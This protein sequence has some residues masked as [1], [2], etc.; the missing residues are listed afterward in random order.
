[1]SLRKRIAVLL[2][3]LSIMVVLAVPP[4]M[5]SDHD[6]GNKRADGPDANK[7]GGQEKPKNENMKKGQLEL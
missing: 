5:A 7:G 3:A 2:S 1:M 4:V 6:E